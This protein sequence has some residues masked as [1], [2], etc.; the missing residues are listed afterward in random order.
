M[1]RTPCT[2]VVALLLAVFGLADA[3]AEDPQR[4]PSDL[5]CGLHWG[6]DWASTRELWS[7]NEWRLWCRDSCF[8]PKTL[9]AWDDSK[10]TFLNGTE[11]RPLESDRPDF[12][13]A[14]STV[15]YRRN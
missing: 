6:G 11:D 13:E 10:R 5:E 14:S 1:T 2:A 7:E 8:R 15:G 3:A 9:Y 4:D 12:T